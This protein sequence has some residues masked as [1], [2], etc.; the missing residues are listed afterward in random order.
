MR[1]DYGFRDQRRQTFADARACA[2]RITLHVFDIAYD[3]LWHRLQRRNTAP[4]DTPYP[5]S[6]EQPR[7]AW[8][9]FEP[10]TP[11]ELAAVD[12]YE[13]HTG[14]LTGPRDR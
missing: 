13:L 7:W 5:I 12:A 11:D 2:A 10:P 1:T 14:G 6:E 4:D 3:T 9:L 8:E